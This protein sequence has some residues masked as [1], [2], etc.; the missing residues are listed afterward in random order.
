MRSDE[1]KEGLSA[2]E[3][4]EG[5]SFDDQW[6]RLELMADPEQTKWDLSDADRAA[7]R[8]LLDAYKR[9]LEI[10]RDLAAEARGS[11]RKVSDWIAKRKER[12]ERGRGNENHRTGRR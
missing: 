9:G 10:L 7:I 1:P 8:A 4:P 3:K 6:S 2:P 11:D 5:E 12:L